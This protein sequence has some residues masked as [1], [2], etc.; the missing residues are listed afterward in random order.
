MSSTPSFPSRLARLGA[1]L[2]LGA[3]ALLSGCGGAEKPGNGPAAQGPGGKSPPTVGVL[4]VQPGPVTLVNEL[5]GRLEATRVAQVRA[6]VAGIVLKR[7]FAEGSVVQAG[8]VLFEIDPA[9]YTAALASAEATLARAA[10]N[11]MQADALVERYRPLAAAQ[12]ISQQEWTAAQAAQKQAAAD[13]AAARAAVQSARINLGY[14]RVTAPIAG[15]TGRAQV[16]EGALVGQ[17]DATPLVTIQ[18]T[19]PIYV[20]FTQSAAEVMK[21]RRAFDA[22]Q[23]QPAP[24]GAARVALVL[25]DG[26]VYAKPGR[27]LFS[28][29]TVDPATGQIGLRA[30]VPNPKGALLPGLYVRVRIEQALAP[31]AVL[32]PQQAVTRS[33]QGDTVMVLGADGKLSPRTVRIDGQQGGRWVVIDGLKAGEQVMVDGFQKIAML[34]PGTPVQGVPWQEGGA[35]TGGAGNAGGNAA[36]PG[37]ASAAAA[38]ASAPASAASR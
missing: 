33:P 9:P 36:T 14:T 2:T 5:P 7:R 22:G 20:N 13:I 17:G 19:D 18:Q 3:A 11:A 15:R 16:T 25:E 1:L 35:A 10:A 12:A 27:L 8:Q 32:L 6:R 38:S 31:E 30:E 21:L 29:L 24:G 26:S 23:L 34:P 37:A 28:D 4:T